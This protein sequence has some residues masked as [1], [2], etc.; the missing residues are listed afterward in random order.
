MI[1]TAARLWGGFMVVCATAF[2]GA[3]LLLSGPAG[4]APTTSPAYGPAT[5]PATTTPT[6]AAPAPAPVTTPAIA[7]TGA[8]LAIMFTVGAVAVGT[9]GMLV[10]A[11]RRRRSETA[12]GA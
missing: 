6:T 10:L 9:G 2:V 1:G 11:A 3:I 8:D 12:Q 4:A 7:F 5:A